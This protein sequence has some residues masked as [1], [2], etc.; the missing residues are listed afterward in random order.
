MMPY[1]PNNVGHDV[2]LT[3]NCF[4]VFHTKVCQAIAMPGRSLRKNPLRHVF[5][6]LWILGIEN[7]VIF[8]LAIIQLDP[9]TLGHLPNSLLF[10]VSLLLFRDLLEGWTAFRFDRIVTFAAVVLLEYGLGRLDVDRNRGSK[11]GRS[12][13]NKCCCDKC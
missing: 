11:R 9:R 6:H 8:L 7:L 4:S 5:Q 12:G 10:A 1:T 2:L 13:G 3:L